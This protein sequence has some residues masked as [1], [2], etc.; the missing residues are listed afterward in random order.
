MKLT[1]AEAFNLGR[2][3]ENLQQFRFTYEVTVKIAQNLRT[4]NKALPN[5]DDKRDE[6][7]K[8][9]NYPQETDEAFALVVSDFEKWVQE[10]MIEITLIKF[11]KEELVIGIC[12]HENHI[13]VAVVSHLI[14]MLDMGN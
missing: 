3:I 5:E 9:H 7:L 11:T 14:P 1:L 13:T 4:L 10:T 2:A 6:I 12:D 8:A